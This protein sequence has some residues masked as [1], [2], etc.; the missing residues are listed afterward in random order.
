MK[1][2]ETVT[3][4]AAEHLA[5][6]QREIEDW[7]QANQDL[8]AELQRTELREKHWRA[9][10]LKEWEANHAEQCGCHHPGAGLCTYYPLP[11]C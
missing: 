4:T 2:P 8:A 6:L 1:P 11:A 10:Y 3:M 5:A 9:A 7:R